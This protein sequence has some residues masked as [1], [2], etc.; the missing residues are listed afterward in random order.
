[1]NSM[2]SVFPQR[3]PGLEGLEPGE[4]WILSRLA[5]APKIQ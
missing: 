2:G 4:F 3:L 1:M 5:Q